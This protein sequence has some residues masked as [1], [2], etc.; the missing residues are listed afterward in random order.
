MESD[1][2]ARAEDL[3]QQLEAGADFAELAREYSDDKA[4]AAKG[5]DLGFFRA[6][7]PLSDVVK[8]TVFRMA[9]G[10]TSKPVRDA[11]RFY[12]FRLT[13]KEPRPLEEV[14]QS[15]DTAISR[16]ALN[17]RLAEIRGDIRIFPKDPEWLDSR[18]G[19]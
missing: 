8:A 9:P 2:Q 6:E 3:Y 4:S 10:E 19:N 1:A 7:D 13:E 16:A 18:P 12:I 11:G 15:I 14:E 5:G 17:N